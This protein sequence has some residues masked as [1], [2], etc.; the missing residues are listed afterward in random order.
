M[1]K[2]RQMPLFLS[3]LRQPARRTPRAAA[4]AVTPAPL[5]RSLRPAV[6]LL[7]AGAFAVLGACSNDAALAESVDRDDV[8]TDAGNRADVGPEVDTTPACVRDP[9]ADSD[10]DGLLDILEDRDRDCRVDEGET[11][12]DNADSDGDGL[13]DGYE[14]VDLNGTWDEA[15]G[16]FNPRVADTDGDGIADSETPLAAVCSSEL[17]SRA[18]V[19]WDLIDSHR[20]V[21][22]AGTNADDVQRLPS[23]VA[24]IT[25]SG[26]LAFGH[27][28]IELTPQASAQELYVDGT[29]LV[30]VAQMGDGWQARYALASGLDFELDRVNAWLGLGALLPAH[31]DAVQVHV[32][33]DA[34][35]GD[36]AIAA[37]RSDGDAAAAWL[38]QASVQTEAGGTGRL[39]ARCGTT[40]VAA[41]VGDLTIV[42]M[43]NTSPHGL[44]A[45]GTA[46]EAVA[47]VVRERD[48]QG[49]TTRVIL[50]RADAHLNGST[51]T[52]APESTVTS[53]AALRSAFAALTPGESEQRMWLNA[54]ALLDGLRTDE[55]ALGDVVLVAVAPDEDVEFREGVNLGY[56]GHPLG[57]PLE[58]G[59]IRRSLTEFYGSKFAAAEA[60]VI[61]LR[62]G[63]CQA[64]V[65]RAISL[66]DVPLAASGAF[67]DLCDPL[68]SALLAELIEHRLGVSALARVTTGPA[69]TEVAVVGTT[70]MAPRPFGADTGVV[71]AG[72]GDL[73]ASAAYLYWEAPEEPS[74]RP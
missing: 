14:D 66:V 19:G 69:S 1:K 35:G 59:A 39:R 37:A 12:P 73:D 58:D 22:P 31:F 33:G 38:A 50:G 48:A 55:R 27:A 57:A 40:S 9:H 18:T 2:P 45:A 16:E 43:L 42:V 30:A 36:I 71:A 15:R 24:L 34:Y 46:I 11:D 74:N 23:G 54:A 5:V 21:L 68:G 32:T 53:A 67:L 6:R 61:A 25:D 10:G 65:D 7:A 64:P 26:A 41:P 51:G 56:D 60:G 13:E 28:P 8:C 62:A 47:G 17:L 3:P 70:A 20:Y 63:G 72:R 4:P 29:N 49:L 44:E 52:R